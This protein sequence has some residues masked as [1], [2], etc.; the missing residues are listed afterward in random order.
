MSIVVNGDVY[1]C[2]M[3]YDEF[4]KFGNIKDMVILE[5]FMFVSRLLF[6]FIIVDFIKE[7]NVCKFRYLCGGGCCVNVFYK[8]S[9]VLSKDLYCLMYYNFYNIIFSLLR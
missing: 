7:C 8:N 5:I 9:D 4:F 6:K 1:L 3:F 2:Y